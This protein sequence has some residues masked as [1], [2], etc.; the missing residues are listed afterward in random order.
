MAVM[1]VDFMVVPLLVMVLATIMACTQTGCIV[2]HDTVLTSE[3][4]Q[5]G[6]KISYFFGE[7]NFP[8]YMILMHNFRISIE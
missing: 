1:V 7:I 5:P 3:A 8:A 2:V 6:S 4:N